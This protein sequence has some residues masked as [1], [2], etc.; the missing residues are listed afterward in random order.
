MASAILSDFSRPP[1]RA[2][3]RTKA[4]SVR[5]CVVDG[6]HELGTA[7]LADANFNSSPAATIWVIDS[8][9]TIGDH[10]MAHAATNVAGVAGRNEVFE[11]VVPAVVVEVIHHERAVTRCVPRHP[12]NHL[13]APMAWMRA[14][15]ELVIQ[16]DA[17]LGNLLSCPQRMIGAVN[18]RVACGR[19][20][21]A[22]GHPRTL[23]RTE[24]TL[25]EGELSEQGCERLPARFTGSMDGIV[26]A[27]R[28]LQSSC[29]VP[30]AVDAAPRF[31]HAAFPRLQANSTTQ[32][33]LLT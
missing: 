19:R 23:E 9:N 13:S 22:T 11:G 32:K 4:A 16:Q 3:P 30:R 10:A 29:A 28:R 27:H 8:E 6:K 24:P 21:V 5:P 15:A 12:V 14:G 33:G 25:I 31:L 17:M 1:P 7:R 20:S 2:R 26:G 18:E